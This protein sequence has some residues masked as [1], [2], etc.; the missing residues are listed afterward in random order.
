LK[1]FLS[2][3]LIFTAIT[4]KSQETSPLIVGAV[5]SETGAHAG[6][7]ADYRKALL[8]WRDEVNAAGGL[9]GRQV[10][11]RLLD[12]ASEAIKAG[13]LYQQ[14]IR[15]KADALIGPYGTAATL[16]AAAEAETAR[17]V[18]IN[19]AGWSREVHKRSPRFVFQSATPYNAY[20]AG[21]LE[22]ARDA[23]YKKLFIL[24]RDEPAAREMAVGTLAAALKLGLSASEVGVYGGGADDFALLVAKAR[25]EQAEAWVAFG[26]PRD[27]AEM[28][29][30]FKRLGYAPPLFLAR[31]T[32]S[33]KFVEAVG[34][35]AEF[36]LGTMEYDPRFATPGNATFVK[37]FTARWSSPPGAAAAEGYAAASVLAAGLRS[38]GSADPGKLRAALAAL[39]TATV[40]GDFKVDPA[41]GE[42]IAT[43]P[44]VVQILKGRAEIVWPRAL[45]TAKPVLPYPAW[46]ER[47]VLKPAYLP[48]NP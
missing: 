6:L 20:G 29:K 13:P 3:F 1:Y 40:L 35:D 45:E 48:Q 24:T 7:A 19:G 36:S 27:A 33:P 21:V 30:S 41:T 43:R 10:E 15:E 8:L 37:A 18:L 16:V 31:G 32:A 14:L 22:M 4:V 23:G 5:V 38:A 39:S 28:V 42:Q 11:L 46:S 25:A 9:L 17:R 44:A 34:Q 26:E 47:R 12:D 2:L